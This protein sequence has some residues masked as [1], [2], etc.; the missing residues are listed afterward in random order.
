VPDENLADGQVPVELPARPL[1][2]LLLRLANQAYG[3][4]VDAALTEA[5]FAGIRPAHANVFPFV[6]PDGV[7]V[8]ELAR[9]A[10]MRKQSMAQAVEQLERLGY[11]E[12]RPDPADG[13]ARRVF[14]TER[15]RAVGPVAVAAGRAVEAQWSQVVGEERLEQLRATLMELL[16]AQRRA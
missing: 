6:S 8:A 11:V 16:N 12:R 9:L 7:S 1:V 5:G 15:G 13:R 4:E 2:G 10:R 3:S 14:L